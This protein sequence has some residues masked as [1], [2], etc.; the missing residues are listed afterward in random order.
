M[1]KTITI[2][3]LFMVTT[4]TQAQKLSDLNLDSVLFWF[5][6]GFHKET[7]HEIICGVGKYVISNLY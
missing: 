6:D 7:N 3:M 4:L 1:K 5:E 2:L